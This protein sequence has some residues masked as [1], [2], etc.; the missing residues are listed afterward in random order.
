MEAS[1]LCFPGVQKSVLLLAMVYNS[2]PEQIKRCWGTAGL[3]LPVLLLTYPT[4]KLSSLGCVSAVKQTPDRT[5]QES[6]V[7]CE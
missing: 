6:Q 7:I 1:S 5:I 3:F 4:Q 2:F